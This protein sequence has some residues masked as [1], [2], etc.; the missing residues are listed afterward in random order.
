MLLAA[1]GPSLLRLED[2]TGSTVGEIAYIFT[3]RATGYFLASLAAGPLYSK[4]NGNTI[5]AVCMLF[6]GASSLV[7]PYCQTVISLGAVLSLQGFAMGALDSGGNV[8][9]IWL[10]GSEVNPYMQALHMSFG[11][12][13]VIA[14]SLVGACLTHLDS[15]APVFW[16]FGAIHVLLSLLIFR[17]PP[18]PRESAHAG[19]FC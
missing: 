19:N 8:M 2:Q 15:V 18:A 13:A 4:F 7:V 3:L 5:T 10:Y 6:A 1:P 11:L 17:L 14:P 16:L 12:G 9:V